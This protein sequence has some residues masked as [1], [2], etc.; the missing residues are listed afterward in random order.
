MTQDTLVFSN[1]TLITPVK[2]IKG[3]LVIEDGI[4]KEIRKAGDIK[5]SGEVIDCSGLFVG[6]GLVDT[7]VHGGA[8]N[9]FSSMEA[10]EISKGARYHLLQVQPAW[11]LHQ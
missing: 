1:G 9:D 8:G 11:F 5:K 7:H 2:K 4:I 3:D 6:P 10:E